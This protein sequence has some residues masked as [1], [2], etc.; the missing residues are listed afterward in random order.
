MMVMMIVMMMAMIIVIMI[1]ALVIS[2]FV[3]KSYK[4]PINCHHC[5]E[6]LWGF[7]CT[8]YSCEGD[9]TITITI[10]MM[11]ST[12]DRP[13]ASQAAKWARSYHSLIIF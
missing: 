3:K 1:M 10:T 2:S 6:Y 13:L 4:T 5:A 11:E 12:I 9:V 8:G 7:A